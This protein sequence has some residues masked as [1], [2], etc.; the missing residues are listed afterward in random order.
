M[1]RDH[2]KSD[3]VTLP[4]GDDRNPLVLDRGSL[5]SRLLNGSSET[6]T[7]RL[8][9]HREEIEVGLAGCQLQVGTSVSAHV[10]NLEVRIDHRAGGGIAGDQQVVSLALEVKSLRRFLLH[11]LASLLIGSGDTSHTVRRSLTE[12]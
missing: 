11:R 6:R 10:Q 1:Q 12:M 8:V 9:G 3:I 4:G 5:L 2:L 7:Q